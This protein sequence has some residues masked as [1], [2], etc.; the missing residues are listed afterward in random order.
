GQVNTRSAKSNK[1]LVE[2]KRICSSEEENHDSC[3]PAS[4]K[5]LRQG[6]SMELEGSDEVSLLMF[7]HFW[8]HAQKKYTYVRWT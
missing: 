1:H 8:I 5:P 3:E 2:K 7:L 4:P 6:S